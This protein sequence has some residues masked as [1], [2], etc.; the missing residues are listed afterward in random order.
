MAGWLDVNWVICQFTYFFGSCSRTTEWYLFLLLV[1]ILLNIACFLLAYIIKNFSSTLHVFYLA[2]TCCLRRTSSS[3]MCV[4]RSHHS[5]C[6]SL[7]S[8]APSRYM[9][10]IIRWHVYVEFSSNEFSLFALWR[11]YFNVLSFSHFCRLLFVSRE[12]FFS[13]QKPVQN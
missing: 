6:V 3:L 12:R 13:S 10:V 5:W 2:R 9:F 8:L 4:F 1:W 7:T 11:L